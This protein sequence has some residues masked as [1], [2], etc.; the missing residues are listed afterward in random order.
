[1]QTKADGLIINNVQPGDLISSPFKI[2]GLVTGNGWFGFEGQVGSVDLI[3]NSGKVIIA[4]PLKATSD[5]TQL[6]FS[7]TIFWTLTPEF[8]LVKYPCDFS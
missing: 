3:N 1:M 8:M 5:W 4:A 2:T 7:M 6:P